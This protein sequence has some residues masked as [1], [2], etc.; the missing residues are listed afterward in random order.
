[1]NDLLV[2]GICV[3]GWVLVFGIF[4]LLS[5]SVLRLLLT[6]CGKKYESFIR[7]IDDM[8]KHESKSTHSY[9]TCTENLI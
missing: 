9:I 5:V 4:H 1:M 6:S 8:S 2:S 3:S 7:A